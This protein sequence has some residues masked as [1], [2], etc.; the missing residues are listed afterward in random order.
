MAGSPHAPD[1]PP[2][3]HEVSI[4]T[5]APAQVLASRYMCCPV[6]I[7]PHIAITWAQRYKPPYKS[8][9]FHASS[10]F[11]QYRLPSK[12]LLQRPIFLA[13]EPQLVADQLVRNG[14][15]GSLKQFC[16]G[17]EVVE[18]H[19]TSLS[20]RNK[21]TRRTFLLFTKKQG[22]VTWA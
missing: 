2:H 19:Q 17:E 12:Q 18:G 7:S 6:Y 16:Y 10:S 3:Q 22:S 20:G 4:S 1:V 11:S 13:T 5:P 15:F 8:F 9:D 21:K 14:H